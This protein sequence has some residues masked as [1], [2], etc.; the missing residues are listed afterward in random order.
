MLQRKCCLD[1]QLYINYDVQDF[2]V[3]VEDNT[4][5]CCIC[6]FKN[7]VVLLTVFSAMVG[8]LNYYYHYIERQ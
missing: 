3:S 6:L 8:L 5:H 2:W 7:T 4:S 1:V